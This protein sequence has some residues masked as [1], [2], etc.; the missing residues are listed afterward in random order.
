M[1]SENGN[2][3]LSTLVNIAQALNVEVYELFENFS[4]D[5]IVRGYLEAGDKTY[6]INNF[7]DLK[8]AY[9]KLIAK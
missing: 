3:T 1:L 2:P 5:M 6:R 9:N 7:N 8:I 4:A